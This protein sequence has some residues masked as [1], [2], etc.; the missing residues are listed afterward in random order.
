MAARFQDTTRGG[1]VAAQEVQPCAVNR[2]SA[3]PDSR[4]EVV[5]ISLEV[6]GEYCLHVI[7][8]SELEKP[9]DAVE[10]RPGRIRTIPEPL[11]K[12]LSL[13]V[14]FERRLKAVV[15]LED[16]GQA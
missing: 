1:N 10:S 14:D 5:G 4:P 11:E 8:P 12:C 6:L 16:C 13:C 3:G 2:D 7:P 9:Q 15:L